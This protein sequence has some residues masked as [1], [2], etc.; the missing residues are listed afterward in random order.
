MT[1]A[2]PADQSSSERGNWTRERLDRPRSCRR[3][4][5]KWCPSGGV[6]VGSEPAVE[7]GA[8]DAQAAVGQ[9]DALWGAALGPPVVERG[10][11]DLEF[12]AD[13]GNGLLLVRSAGHRMR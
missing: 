8:A 6:L 12:A 13:L 10:P 1:G 7:D 4:R 9:G 11:G 5:H 3:G 2:S